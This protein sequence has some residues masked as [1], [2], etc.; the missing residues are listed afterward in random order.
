MD[1]YLVH[2]GAVDGTEVFNV[3]RMMSYAA[4]QLGLVV[5]GAVCEEDWSAY[6]AVLSGQHRKV[7]H[8]MTLVESAWPGAQI[9]VRPVG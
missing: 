4:T 8:L 7:R 5:T 6:Q 9:E 1:S 3:D 2:I